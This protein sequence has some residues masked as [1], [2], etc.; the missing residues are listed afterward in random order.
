MLRMVK[1]GN[2][3][4]ILFEDKRMNLDQWEDR[5][6]ISDNYGLYNILIPILKRDYG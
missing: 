6:K 3:Y 1:E 5:K 2:E 4:F